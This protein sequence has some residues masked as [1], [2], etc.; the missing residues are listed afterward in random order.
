MTLRPEADPSSQARGGPFAIDLVITAR[1]YGGAERQL[2]Y[3][4]NGLRSRGHRIG[5]ISLF[6]NSEFE[7]DCS[8]LGLNHRTLRVRGGRDLPLSLFRFLRLI[9]RDR[10]AV[11]LG[12]LTTAN[13]MCGLA[14]LASP[15]TRIVWS[16]HTTDF[17]T[18]PHDRFARAAESVQRRL[19]RICH[20]VI[21]CSV[22]GAEEAVA[23]GYP[24]AKIRVVECGIDS[25]R[26][27]PDRAGGRRI[28]AEWGVAPEEILIG[29][30][31]R[32]VPEKDHFTFLAA[33]AEF[34]RQQPKARFVCLG[35][36][37]FPD[38]AR[39]VRGEASRLGLE[40]RIVWAG[41]RRDMP[42]AYS[43]F[44]ILTLTSNAGEAVSNAVGE[45]MAC[46]VPCVVTD[47]G[48]SLR[49]VG[50]TGV[51][52]PPR[53]PDAL[54]RGWTTLLLSESALSAKT[55]RR[56]EENYGLARMVTRTEA[57]LSSLI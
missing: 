14:R 4:A 15:G 23:R 6:S 9:R 33:A 19:S 49:L 25:T 11:V 31:A 57:L 55:R 53:E 12:Y 20:L 7:Q 47:V 30:V 37:P 24:G 52:V 8:E 29:L 44:D 43:A 56:I 38:Y 50:D 27:R 26:F 40:G 10:P 1:Q 42:A 36:E 22:A 46:G 45:A 35:Q 16:I 18:V 3:L 34:T 28:R 13:L 32:V 51:V 21:V 39:S 5:V 41:V 17:A 2:L 54:V 48:D